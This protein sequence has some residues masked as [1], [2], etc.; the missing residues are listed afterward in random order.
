[1]N[2][3]AHKMKLKPV[4]VTEYMKARLFIAGGIATLIFSTIVIGVGTYLKNK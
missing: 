1:M 3:Y 4:A 2:H